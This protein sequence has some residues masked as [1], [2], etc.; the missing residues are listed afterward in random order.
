M[1]SLKCT[2]LST[3]DLLDVQGAGTYLARLRNHN[4]TDNGKV[5]SRYLKNLTFK[6]WKMHIKL[7]I[8][9]LQKLLTL[10][11]PG[12]QKLAPAG[13]GGADTAPLLTPLPFIQT[14]PNLVWANTIIWQVL[15][16]NFKC[17]S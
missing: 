14:E 7:W 11:M 10:S 1:G 3:L 12:F 6:A 2:Y 9:L 13:G 15:V 4:A 16:Q 17:S 8:Y 5:Y